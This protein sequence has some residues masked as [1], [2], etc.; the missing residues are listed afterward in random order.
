[1][2]P[3]AI[4]TLWVCALTVA[5]IAV[6]P[7]QNRRPK[8][9]APRS[10]A[11]KPELI[12]VSTAQYDNA[13]TGANLLE[14]ILNPQNVNASQFGRVASFLV[15]GDVYAQPLYVPQLEIPGK[16]LHNV[17]IVATEK[18]SIYAFAFLLGIWLFVAGLFRI[19]VA[20]ADHQDTGGARWLMACFARVLSSPK[21][22]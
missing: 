8:S 20:I 12:V 5:T 13:R 18:D 15:D 9:P 19:V 3:G 21:V 2:R 6:T 14:T 16:G 10:T 11:R 7:G 17:L 1:M 4:V 22:W